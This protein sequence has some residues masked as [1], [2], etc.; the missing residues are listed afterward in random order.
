MLIIVFI[1][2]EEYFIDVTHKVTSPS[3]TKESLRIYEALK[4]E[5]LDK[6]LLNSKHCKLITLPTRVESS[7]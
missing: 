4:L 5:F 1:K 3:G 6:S 7:V 2:C